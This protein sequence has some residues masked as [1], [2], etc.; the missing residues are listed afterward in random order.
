[1][2][3]KEGIVKIFS[4]FADRSTMHGIGSLASARSLKVKLF[5]SCV[6]MASMGMFLF[7][8]TRIV[9]RYLEFNVVVNIEEVYYFIIHLIVP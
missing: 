6:C 3:K 2:V 5:W 4:S 1:M 8:L 7:M 9:K